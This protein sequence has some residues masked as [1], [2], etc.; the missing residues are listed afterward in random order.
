MTHQCLALKPVGRAARAVLLGSV[1]AGCLAVGSSAN[2]ALSFVFDYNDNA[3]TTEFLGPANQVRRDALE[4]AGS[5]F[6]NYFG[7]LFT[8]SATISLAVQGTNT[9]LPGLLAFAGSSQAF[10]PPFTGGFGNSE[11]VRNKMM[12]NGDLNGA[13]NDGVVGVNWGAP[14]ELNPNV[15][16]AAQGLGNFDFYA[17]LFHEFTHALG[18][19]AG[20]TKDGTDGTSQNGGAQVGG[21]DYFGFWHKYDQFL[22]DCGTNNLIN[23]ATGR[24]TAFYNGDAGAGIP[25][26][27]TTSA[28]FAGANA[29]AANGG[30]PVAI[31]TPDPYEPGSSIGHLLEA[32]LN[33]GAMMKFDRDPNVDEART[34]NAIEIGVL[35][36]IGYTRVSSSNNVPEP[37]S[38]ALVLAGLAGMGIARRRKV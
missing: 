32:G 19:T 3:G 33:T 1:F 21:V 8:N 25:A 2:A 7:S 38:I 6:S 11:V 4:T 31:Y 30:A 22:T 13:A 12:G 36:D 16:V 17:A 34:Y 35:M 20:I 9:P 14:W 23:T 24:T 15:S 5:L 26:A 37:G 27:K 28:C 29:V 10:D 18:F